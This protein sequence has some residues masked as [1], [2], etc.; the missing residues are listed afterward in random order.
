VSPSL[1]FGIDLKDDLARFQVIM[2]AAYMPLGDERIKRLFKE[3]GDWYQNKMLN[4]VIQACGRGVRS[5]SDKCVTYILDKCITD[6]ILKN[7]SKLPRYFL[8]R[9]N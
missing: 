9:F 8:K 1:A 3:D 4:N 6:A 2:K 7:R 5:K